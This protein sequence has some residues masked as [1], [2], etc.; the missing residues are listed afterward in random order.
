MAVHRN[1][2]L[3]VLTPAQFRRCV[4]PY[5]PGTILELKRLWPA[6]RKRGMSVGSSLSSTLTALAAAPG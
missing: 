1:P 5:F 2:R 4:R 6:A 3:A